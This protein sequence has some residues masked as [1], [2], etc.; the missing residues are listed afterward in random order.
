VLSPPAPPDCGDDT[1]Y[2]LGNDLADRETPDGA[3]NIQFV[4]L[5]LA[6][7]KS[8]RLTAWDWFSLRAGG[9]PFPC[10]PLYVIWN[11]YPESLIP[12]EKQRPAGR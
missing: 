7:P 9:K 1:S 3:S 8:G 10:R 11:T 4:D 2:R 12:N 5:N 6:F